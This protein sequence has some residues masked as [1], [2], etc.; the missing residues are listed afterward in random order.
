MRPYR[1]LFQQICSSDNLDRACDAAAKGKR[2]KKE[3]A[4]FLFQREFLLRQLQR[5]LREQRYVPRNEK[6]L[7][8]MD[9][10]PRAILVAPFQ[11]RVVHHAVCDIVEPLLA[12]S[13]I[14][15]TWACLKG[16]GTVRALL[17]LRQF[18]NQH[19]FA[20]K[21]DIHKYFLSIPHQG[22]LA[23]L[24]R[25]LA[26]PPL[27]ALLRTL[28]T[29][30]PRPYMSPEV[31]AHLKDPDFVPEEG[32]GV[33]IG[34]LT[35]QVFGNFY[36]SRLDHHIKRVLKVGAYLRYMDDMVLLSDSRAQLRQWTRE[37][38]GY[39]RDELGLKLR[40]DRTRLMACTGRVSFLGFR[41][42]RTEQV[43]GR[44]LLGR[45]RRLLKRA[46]GGPYSPHALLQ[47][48]QRLVAYRGL[49]FQ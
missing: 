37:I 15:D 16:R 20:L 4:A 45:V 5:E 39:L 24:E 27:L 41:V 33:A 48:Q 35:S 46:A 11:N 25:R 19:R 14:Y 30:G 49:L 43:P 10:K 1:H 42:G 29:H 22:L 23:E 17:R 26:D 9:P 21:L 34:H 32:R 31:Q 18:M 47:F 13:Y 2:Y 38:Q 7:L 40:E 36:L 8:V 6:L 28:V 3:V 44:R 12:R